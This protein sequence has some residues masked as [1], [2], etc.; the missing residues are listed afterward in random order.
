MS[1]IEYSVLDFLPEKLVKELTSKSDGMLC[2]VRIR[3]DCPTIAKF[4]DKTVKYDKFI[5]DKK[6]IENILLKVCKNSI[7][8]YEEQIKRGF[9]TSDDGERVGLAGEFVKEDG[10]IIAIKNVTSLCIRIPNA[11]YGVS[12]VFYDKFYNDNG[13][14][15]LVL[16]RSGV[17][18]TTFIRDLSLLISNDYSKNVVVVDERNEIALKSLFKGALNGKQIDVLTYSDKD[19]G[20][21]QAV[22]TLNP[23]VIVTDELV[24][25]SDLNSIVDTIYCGT[26]VIATAHA[27]SPSD[28]FNRFNFDLKIFDYYVVI[29]LKGNVRQFDYFDKDLKKLCL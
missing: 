2:E 25:K 7:H 11:V 17:G 20:F 13:G 15:V 4:I 21:T 22:R 28:F 26:N 12:K 3:S 19:F 6:D 1:K 14:N 8:S 29:S 24:S 5:Y 9:V 16:S 10:K 18:K 23:N 27:S